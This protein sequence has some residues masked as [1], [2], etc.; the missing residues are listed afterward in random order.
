VEQW[1]REGAR[2]WYD[3]TSCTAWQIHAALQDPE[4]A[5]ELSQVCGEHGVVAS[6]E[7]STRGTSGHWGGATSSSS[8]HSASRSE[9]RRPLIKPDELLQ[10]ARADEAFVIL[11]SA[12]PLRCGRAIYF[13]RLAA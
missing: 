1:G 7:G 6:S 4:T 8:G 9:M 11:R 5:R 10:D 13:Q 12:K 2:A 3:G